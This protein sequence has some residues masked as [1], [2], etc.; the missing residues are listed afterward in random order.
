MKKEIKNLIIISI[1]DLRSDCI[2]AN[3]HK[4]LLKRYNIK[5]NLKT[6][7]LDWF[8]NNGTF[9]S[10]CISTAPYT[11]NSHASILT[12]QWPFI[13]GVQSYRETKLI[14]PT[15]LTILKEAGFKTLFQ[16]D[17]P[18]ILGDD[19]NFRQNVDK[20]IDSDESESFKWLNINKNEKK[21]CFFHF[22]DVHA[23]Y[24]LEKTGKA[25]VV[26]LQK[27]LNLLKKFK[28]NRVNNIDGMYRAKL[29][30]KNITEKIIY[31]NYHI[32]IDFLR[33]NSLF[34]EI[35]DLYIEGINYFEKNRFSKFIKGLWKAGM[36]EGS[37]IIILGD[38]GEAF[39]EKVFGHDK[40]LSNELLTIPL[41]IYGPN[42]DKKKIY[43]EQARSID[44]VPTI[45]SLLNLGKIGKDISGTS[46]LPY[47]KNKN[48]SYS[49][50]WLRRKGDKRDN[51]C[52]TK[53]E[54][55]LNIASVMNLNHKLTVE[56]DEN[57][58]VIK[59]ILCEVSNV[60]KEVNIN[61]NKKH[62]DELNRQLNKFNSIARKRQLTFP[63]IKRTTRE[64]EIINNLRAV[65]YNI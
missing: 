63:R 17:A 7:I 32:V 38:H 24:G 12:G 9:F 8:L 16:T 46:L 42:V 51:L 48:L 54:C 10:K 44:I 18:N 45:L 28:L 64:D 20:F 40:S 30:G 31:K 43:N 6:P 19:I 23:P 58:I 57:D 22:Y 49:Q 26:N 13:H 3:P 15:I 29:Q 27:T 50:F 5:A 39:N 41:I 59:R 37:L 55:Y 14:S 25:P 4:E 11:T 36:M 33:R 53:R 35:A 2:A 52:K 1:D 61:S 60:E 56:Y 65:G 21:A 47:R 34:D 62:F